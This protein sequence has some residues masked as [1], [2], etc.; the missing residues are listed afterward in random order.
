MSALKRVESERIPKRESGFIMIV[1]IYAKTYIWNIRY[2][3][4]VA[5]PLSGIAAI[6]M[7]Y[8]MPADEQRLGFHTACC[9]EWRATAPSLDI[10]PLE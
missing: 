6:V 8:R 5:V 10:G 9:P 1:I 4:I 7:D 3:N 2:G